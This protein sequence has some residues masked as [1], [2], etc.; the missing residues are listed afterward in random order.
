[1][2]NT[3]RIHDFYAVFEVQLV[4]VCVCVCAK[5]VAKRHGERQKLKSERGKHKKVIKK[6]DENGLVGCIERKDDKNN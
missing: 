2:S 4:C 5:K 6:T 1:M 3:K